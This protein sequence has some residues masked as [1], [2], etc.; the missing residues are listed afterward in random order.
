MFILS[1]S[2]TVTR[3]ARY[4]VKAGLERLCWHFNTEM[5]VLKW[6]H[7]RRRGMC[8]GNVIILGPKVD[9]YLDAMLHSY[10]HYLANLNHVII[11]QER[12]GIKY[13]ETLWKVVLFYHK[14]P[15]KYSWWEEYQTVFEFGRNRIRSWEAEKWM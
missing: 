6:S 3:D 2:L 15:T 4:L 9:N 14:S 7:G 12:H 10:A 1:S 8:I 5:P 13:L 11:P